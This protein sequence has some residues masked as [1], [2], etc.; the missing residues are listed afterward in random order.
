LLWAG[1]Q[2]VNYSFYFLGKT[3]PESGDPAF[4]SAPRVKTLGPAS[5]TGPGQ[6]IGTIYPEFFPKYG[7]LHQPNP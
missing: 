4:P 7:N 6:I 3:G 2:I 1:W 5:S